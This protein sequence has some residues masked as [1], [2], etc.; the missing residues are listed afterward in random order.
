MEAFRRLVPLPVF[1]TGVVRDP[2][3]AGSIPVRLRQPAAGVTRCATARWTRDAGCPAPTRCWP[4]RS[5]PRPPR[6]S[7]G[8]G[9]RPSSPRRRSGPAAARSTPT[10]SGTPRSA[11]LPVAGPPHGAQRHRRRA[12]HQPRPGAAVTPPPSPRV[13]AAAGH[14]DVELD[15]GTGRRAR[16]G[17]DAL[18]ALA[19]AVPDAARR[20]RGQQRRRRA[21][22]GRHRA[23]RRPGD[24]GQPGRAGRDRRRVPPARPAGEHRRP[25]AGGGHHQPHHPRRLRRRGR[26]GDRVRAQGAPVELPGHRL[27]LGRAACGELA[28]LGVPVV[29]DIGSGLLA[30][31][32]LLPDEPDA[33]STLRAGAAPGHRQRRQAARRPAGGPA[34]RRRR[35]WSSGCAGT[36]WPGRCGWTSSPSPRSPPPCTVRTPRPGPRCT[37]TRPACAAAWSGCVTGSARTAARRRSYRRSPWSVAAARRASSWTRGR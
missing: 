32:P 16:R 36:R 23:G 18:D 31:D 27:H 10:R 35:R 21:G 3:Q 13:V 33:A 19:A 15:L 28:T 24:R 29:A 22:P 2:G 8:T 20:A 34:A 9:S 1:K 7:A 5:W 6:P 37:P 17:R 11:A 30:P 25:A 4:T 12:A 26:P 14:T